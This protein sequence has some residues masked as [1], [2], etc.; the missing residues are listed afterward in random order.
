M[1]KK[2]PDHLTSVYVVVDEKYA[3]GKVGQLVPPGMNIVSICPRLS[4]SQGD[5][6]VTL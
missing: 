1:A 2:L 5:A 6:R 4:D 3:K